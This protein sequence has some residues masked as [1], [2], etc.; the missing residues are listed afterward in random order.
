[1]TTKLSNNTTIRQNNNMTHNY[2]TTQLYDN[3]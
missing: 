2:M 1:M 3:T